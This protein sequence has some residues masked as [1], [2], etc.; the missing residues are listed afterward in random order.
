MPRPSALLLTAAAAIL[1]AGC[2]TVEQAVT[3]VVG[4]DFAAVLTGAN[5]VP[6][7]DPDGAGTA[8]ISIDDATDRVCTHLEV[9][10]IGAV[11]AAHIHRGSAGLNGPPVITL[12]APDDD[13][14]NDCDPV[15]DALIDEIRRS[16]GS[17]YVNVH[18]AQYPN[19]AI[20]GQI[21]NIR[22]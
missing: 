20:R 18:T 2:E 4:N 17:F 16:P 6:P 9:R 3:E 22:G 5:E 13:D 11:T 14:S 12:D 21:Y 15:A 7:G 1:I 10:N 8:R 19:G